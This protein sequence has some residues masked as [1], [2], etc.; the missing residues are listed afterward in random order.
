MHIGRES[1]EALFIKYVY[2]NPWHSFCSRILQRIGDWRSSCHGHGC[3]NFPGGI[4]VQIGLRICGLERPGNN[5]KFILLIS[6]KVRFQAQGSD[7]NLVITSGF[8][9]TRRKDGAAWWQSTGNRGVCLRKNTE[10]MCLGC[11]VLQPGSLENRQWEVEDGV[12]EDAQ[13]CSSECTVR[14]PQDSQQHCQSLFRPP[15]C[16]DHVLRP[17]MKHASSGHLGSRWLISKGW[18][19]GSTLHKSVWNRREETSPR[20]REWA[21]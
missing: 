2:Q 12:W 13:V 20:A 18:A 16:P 14:A 8:A 7:L 10:E 15:V 3:L 5:S 11:W 1:R 4:N 17:L 6:G 19:Q 21:R 9:N